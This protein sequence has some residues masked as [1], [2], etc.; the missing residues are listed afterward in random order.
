M[1]EKSILRTMGILLD[2]KYRENLFERGI[3]DYLEKFRT[4]SSSS[5]DG[6]YCYNFSVLANH[7]DTQPSGAINLSKFKKIQLELSLIEPL[8][9][10][11]HFVSQV[12][13]AGNLTGIV[14]SEPIYSY[15]FEL[16]VY[17]E[18][19][20]ILELQNGMANLLF[21]R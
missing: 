10:P 13:T 18:R 20:N 4:N 5:C 17:E 14:D 2:G 9:N 15:A 7:Q 1:A 21:S 6:L 8:F 19:Y 3:Y 16:I 11:N 12:C